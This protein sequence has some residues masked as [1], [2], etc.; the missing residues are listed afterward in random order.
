MDRNQDNEVML[1]RFIEDSGCLASLYEYES[2]LNF[3]EVLNISEN[4]T[5][6]SSFLA[7]LIDPHGSHGLGPLVLK[8]LID[9][10]LDWDSFT[11]RREWEKIDILA[12][13]EKEKYLLCIENKIGT[14]EHTNQLNRYRVS[15]GSYFPDYKSQYIY[16]S[17]KGK[18]ASDPVNWRSMSYAEIL[19]IIDSIDSKTGNPDAAVLIRHYADALRRDIVGDDELKKLCQKIYVKHKTALDLIYAN[20]PSNADVYQTL[21]LWAED[22]N[23]KGEIRLNLGSSTKSCI[24]FMTE[25]MSKII[26][27]SEEPDSRWGTKNHYFYEIWVKEP[28][29]DFFIQIT[30]NTTNMTPQQ[31]SITDR[32]MA[33]RK[34]FQI[35]GK[36]AEFLNPFVAKHQDYYCLSSDDI[37]M[38]ADRMFEELKEFEKEITALFSTES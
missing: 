10:E 28:T 14:A 27:D 18:R 15:V 9:M 35:V 12:V 23:T 37:W 24:Q 30:L 34:D 36:G 21:K 38:C 2:R 8:Q 31:R 4:E 11:V 17:P 6:H 13:S 29:H 16:L 32:I 20:K 3:F 22:K 26:P 5:C 19:D 33:S 25:D 1:T 7:W